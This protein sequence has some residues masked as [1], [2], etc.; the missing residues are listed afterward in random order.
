MKTQSE[1]VKRLEQFG[2]KPSLQR[3]AIMGYLMDNFVHPTVD[4]VFSGLSASIPTLSKTTVYNTLKLLARQGAVLELNID[5]KNLRYDANIFRHAHFRCKQCGS[6]HDV[7]VGSFEALNVK[8][9][10]ELVITESQLYYKGYCGRCK[11]EANKKA[12]EEA[13]EEEAANADP[14]RLQP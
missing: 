7:P 2:V 11:A 10:G 12:A 9:A 13:E 6:V 4:T 8:S 3:I 14:C 1:V 5:D